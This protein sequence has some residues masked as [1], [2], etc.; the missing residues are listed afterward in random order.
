MMESTDD[1]SIASASSNKHVC[2]KSFLEKM[3]DLRLTM[4]YL[5]SSD[6]VLFGH[7]I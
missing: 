7:F 5:A 6:V 2:F 1:N 4:Y 3:S